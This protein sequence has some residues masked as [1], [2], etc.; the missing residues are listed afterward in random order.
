MRTGGDIVIACPLGAKEF[1]IGTASPVA[2]GCLMVRQYQSNT[3]PVVVCV[4][5][6][7]LLIEAAETQARDIFELSSRG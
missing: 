6:D 3:C 7:L 4:P 2:V 1:G 5:D